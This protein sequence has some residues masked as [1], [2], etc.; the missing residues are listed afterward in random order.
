[1]KNREELK[2]PLPDFAWYQKQSAKLKLSPRC[3][4]ASTKLCP[5]YFR[6]SW[7]FG[8]HA[9]I[10]RM[11]AKEITKHEEQL[12]KSPLF[13]KEFQLQPTLW[14]TNDQRH[15]TGFQDC[16][17]EVV[18]D[19]YGVFA[20]SARF[21]DKYD[22]RTQHAELK[23]E[24]AHPDD[25]RWKYLSLTPAHFSECREFSV[26]SHTVSTSK[27]RGARPEARNISSKQRW[28]ILFRDNFT[29]K[30]CGRK[31]PEVA[32]TV[33]HFVSVHADGTKE[34]SNLVAACEACNAGKS[35]R[36]PPQL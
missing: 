25:W 10:E 3:P 28:E 14:L 8:Q 35:N 26:L 22:E 9:V 15:P 27:Q 29:C 34:P 1:M 6:T 21:M 31:P 23:R 20:S 30:Y 13:S 32:L 19:A 11:S 18:Y 4:F 5:R 2:N 36:P 12:D 17:P 33:D 24:N 7:I 16:C